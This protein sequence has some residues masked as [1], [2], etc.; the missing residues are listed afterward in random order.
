MITFYATEVW[1]H[2]L[3]RQI[4]YR[5]VSK[6]NWTNWRW[7]NAILK[8]RLAA[9]SLNLKRFPFVVNIIIPG[10]KL[11]NTYEI[12]SSVVGKSDCLSGIKDPITGE[13]DQ[14]YCWPY[15]Q[16]IQRVCWCEEHTRIWREPS[17][18]YWADGCR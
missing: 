14:W 18:S 2:Y 11:F 15:L 1:F 16:E 6:T 8:M 4:F 7:R 9:S 12:H 10:T 3:E 17:Q 13:K 5:K